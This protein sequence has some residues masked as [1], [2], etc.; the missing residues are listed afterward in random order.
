MASDD[1]AST[2][3]RAR[4]AG[5]EPGA[6]VPQH[7]RAVQVD[8]MK[9]MLKAPGTKRL[10]LKHDEP[11]SNFAL[12]LNLRRYIMLRHLSRNI[13]DIKQVYQYYCST[14]FTGTTAARLKFAVAAFSTSGGR[15]MDPI[16]TSSVGRC[17]LTL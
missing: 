8:P 5:D 2:T 3:N 16:Y 9:S 12:K 14:G 4:F 10:K 1:V 13:K 7:G 6:G 11:L 15:P 17:R